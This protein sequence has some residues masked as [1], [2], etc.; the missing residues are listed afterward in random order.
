[1]FRYMK[2]DLE[3]KPEFM[4]KYGKEQ[5]HP[6]FYS[7]LEYMSLDLP[8]LQDILDSVNFEIDR[9]EKLGP[10]NI[11]RK[12]DIYDAFTFVQ[13]KLYISM[14]YH[15]FLPVMDELLDLKRFKVKRTPVDQWL[16]DNNRY[17][18]RQRIY[19]YPR[20]NILKNSKGHVD[21]RTHVHSGTQGPINNAYRSINTQYEEVLSDD[22]HAVKYL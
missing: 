6:F 7:N 2:V 16:Y 13:N 12:Q 9:I 21:F 14:H 1:M 3:A 17:W 5:I 15:K 19:V 4:Q 11:K 22:V 10:A 18:R 8:T 20:R